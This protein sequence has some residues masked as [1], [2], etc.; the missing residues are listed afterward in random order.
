M[1]KGRL[2][3]VRKLIILL[4]PPSSG[5]SE[6]SQELSRILNATVIS[7]EDIAKKLGYGTENIKKDDVQTVMNEA[8]RQI[9]QHKNMTYILRGFSLHP[10]EAN[11]IANWYKEELVDHIYTVRLNVSLCYLIKKTEYINT[12]S[13]THMFNI[14]K[15]N[16]RDV[17]AILRDVSESLFDVDGEQPTD[18][19]VADI[20]YGINYKLKPY[21]IYTFIEST[22]LNT[23][24][25]IFELRAYQS[26]I[27][28]SYHLVLVKGNVFNKSG[29]YTR[30]HSSCITG[31]IL[32]SN[33]CECGE[34]L[35]LALKVLSTKKSGILFYLF[36]EG[37]GINI[38]NK[39]KAY[40][41][42]AKGMDTVQANLALDLPSELRV[43]DI[44]KEV[45]DDLGVNSIKLMTNNPDKSTKLRRIG[46]LIEDLVPHIIEPNEIN[47]RY[48]NTKKEKMN[49]L[50]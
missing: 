21:K 27:D 33:H 34:Q 25:G 19:V 5:K 46:V 12:D 6:I 47:E 49:H 45:L 41:L 42:Q 11:E 13:I 18:S 4:G 37:R 44:V 24:Y 35:E 15:R 9:A 1:Y 10:F 20:I 32:F 23:K 30:V 50:L 31:D 8:L 38:I 48:L 28:Y 7:W 29:V 43:Y 17:D 3:R 36:Q 22:Q 39:I 14:S 40:K 2:Y 26:K 16:S